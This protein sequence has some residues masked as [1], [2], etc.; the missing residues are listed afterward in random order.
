[1]SVCTSAFHFTYVSS[2]KLLNILWHLDP[3]LGNDRE[4]SNYTTAVTRQQPVSSNRG[5]M[6]SVQSVPRCYRWGQLDV[7]VG[8]LVREPLEF[9]PCEKLVSEAWY[10]SG[11][12][13][14]G[15]VRCWKR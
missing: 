6:F 8:E 12:Q 5:T 7:A 3:L 4:I 14:N 9:S 13:R 11:A 1:M 2:P 10:R 15:N